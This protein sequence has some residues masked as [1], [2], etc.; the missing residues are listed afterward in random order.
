MTGPLVASST[1]DSV[2]RG[3]Y[4]RERAARLD[5]EQLLEQKSRELYEANQ[6]LEQA[7][8][9]ERE[10]A[11]LRASFI[12]VISHEFRTPLTVIKGAAERISKSEA[13]DNPVIRAKC[14][15]IRDAV[16][17]LTDLIEKCTRM[18]QV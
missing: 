16:A 1:D 5:A 10:I 9:K 17:R 15:N 4:E 2:S 11:D 13:A 8:M 18:T 7:L 14:D 3:R 6:R 12:T